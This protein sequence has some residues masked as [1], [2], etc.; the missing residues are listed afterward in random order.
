[1]VGVYGGEISADKYPA[2]ISRIIDIIIGVIGWKSAFRLHSPRE[3]AEEV[4]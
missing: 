3:G 2:S 1:M 4:K